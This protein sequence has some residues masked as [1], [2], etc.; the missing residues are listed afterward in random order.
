LSLLLSDEEGF[1][2]VGVIHFKTITV[3]KR[4]ILM[5]YSNASNSNS[6]AM[7]LDEMLLVTDRPACFATLAYR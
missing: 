4:T 2:I 3:G 1:G 5:V 7:R 6:S